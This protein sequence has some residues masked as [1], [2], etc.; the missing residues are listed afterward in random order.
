MSGRIMPDPSNR[1]LSLGEALRAL[2]LAAPERDVWATLAAELAP[3]ARRPARRRYALPVALAAG[4]LGLAA[5]LL[6]RMP[7]PAPTNVASNVATV[8]QPAAS[9]STND[10]NVAK[11]ANATSVQ[12]A[13]DADLI[14]LE[15]RSQA[16]ERWLHDTRDAASPLPGQ[17][18]AAAAEIENLLGLV[19]VALAGTSR[20]QALPLW[21]RRVNLLEDLTALRYSN[22][23]LAETML[24][25]SAAQAPNRIN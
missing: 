10:A 14:A 21:R 9:I 4:L 11:A 24:A 13:G 2:P 3:Q 16:L 20:E 8:A 17:D 15:N 12:D 19:D 22:Y 1:K 23:R 5:A 6:L 7:Q 25:S 18:L